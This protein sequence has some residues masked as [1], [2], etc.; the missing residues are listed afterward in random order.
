M[1][2]WNNFTKFKASNGEDKAKC[3][4]YKGILVGERSKGTSHLRKHLKSCNAKKQKDTKQQMI[5]FLKTFVD[6][7][8]RLQVF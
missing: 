3:N 7:G 4:H 6:Y 1:N 2:V 8:P 5:S